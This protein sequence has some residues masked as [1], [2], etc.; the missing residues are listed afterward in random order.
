M[1]LRDADNRGGYEC[2]GTGSIWEISVPSSLFYC[3]LIIALNK[4]S[5]KKVIARETK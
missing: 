2:L 1:T 3:E 5:L 4:Q